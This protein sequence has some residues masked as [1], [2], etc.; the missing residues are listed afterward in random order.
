MVNTGVLLDVSDRANSGNCST[1]RGLAASARFFFAAASAAFSAVSLQQASARVAAARV[2]QGKASFAR[3]LAAMALL[4]K[5][6]AGL[7]T[8]PELV[9]MLRASAA[10]P[11]ASRFSLFFVFILSFW[12]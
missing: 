8:C 1:M 4:L 11:T 5:A 9:E 12:L 10:A 6:S 3:G 2:S 7:N